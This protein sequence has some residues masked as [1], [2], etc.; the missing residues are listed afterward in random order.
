MQP[1]PDPGSATSSVFITGATGF[2]GQNLAAGLLASGHRVRV[3][4]RPGLHHDERVPSACE[5]IPANLLDVQQLTRVVA[6][7]SAV[8][9]CAGSVRGRSAADFAA[10]NVDGVEAM[11]QALKNS[12]SPPPV[13][14]ISSLAA[15]RPQLSHYARSKYLGEQVL[16][17]NMDLPWTILRPPA[18]YGPGDKEMLPLLQ[19]IRR[20]YTVHPGPREQRLSLLYVDDLVQAVVAWLAAPHNGVHGTFAI[21]DGTPGGYD[22]PAITTAVGERPARMV[23]VPRL[24]LNL[25]AG[26]NVVLSYV[27]RYAPML[28]PGKVRELVQPDWLSDNHDFTLAAGWRPK[29][30]L[31]EGARRLFADEGNAK[32]H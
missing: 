12:A 13:L 30:Q 8:I 3:L 31:H 11:T 21:D 27:F 32:A 7:S 10:A 24:M 23:H 2:I 5:Q 6:E 29:V 20:G 25:A 14:L 18:V 17:A 26:V 28:T 16:A 1:Q 15:S 9:Y 4:I 19:W 22:W